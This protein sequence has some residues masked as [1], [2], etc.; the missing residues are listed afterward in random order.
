MQIDAFDDSVV[1]SERAASGQGLPDEL[2]IIP[3]EG[4]VNA[5]VRDPFQN[6]LLHLV[7]DQRPGLNVF[8][9]HFDG[10][11]WNVLAHI[12]IGVQGETLRLESLVF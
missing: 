11:A 9:L 4:E 6:I 1:E 8:E 5:A 2:G 12:Q 10:T 3:A 7:F